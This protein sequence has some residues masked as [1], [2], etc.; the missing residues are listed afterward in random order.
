MAGIKTAPGDWFKWQGDRP[1]GGWQDI[2][3]AFGAFAKPAAGPDKGA[4]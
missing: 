1:R 3:G 2:Y 4:D